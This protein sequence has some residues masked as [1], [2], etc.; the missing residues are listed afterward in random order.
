MRFYIHN[1]GD[2]YLFNGPR[3]NRSQRSM[4]QELQR[5]S[6]ATRVRFAIVRVNDT[7]VHTALT[8]LDTYTYCESSN[9]RNWGYK[10]SKSIGE[11]P[12][13]VWPRLRHIY[14][15]GRWSRMSYND[16]RPLHSLIAPCLYL[17]SFLALH[18]HF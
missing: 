17:P 18:Y 10:T 15:V 1:R 12:N 2:I 13:P 14:F 9:I 3:E 11:T 7:I 6:L 5:Y 4:L 8:N 16:P